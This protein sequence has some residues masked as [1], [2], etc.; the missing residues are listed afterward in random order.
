MLGVFVG[1]PR[2]N[3]PHGVSVKS[4][5]T[6]QNRHRDAFASV[7]HTNN[8]NL[9]IREFG[10][11]ASI[12]PRI[13]LGV[14]AT[15]VPIAR[16]P[17][18]TGVASFLESHVT[19]VIGMCAQEEMRRPTTRSIVATVADQHVVG[20]RT[21]GQYPRYT[22]GGR[23]SLVPGGGFKATIPIGR[24]MPNPFPA[25]VGVVGLEDLAPEPI[26]KGARTRARSRIMGMHGNLL[27][28]CA[29]PGG[30]T[31][32]LGHL[33]AIIAPVACRGNTERVKEKVR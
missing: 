24:L 8:E 5:L 10:L 7:P 23:A 6:G 25:G 16:N 22:L 21:I 30:V 33:Y 2:N 9:F 14:G 31:A 17:V 18:C 1:L 3:S 27:C 19:R 13:S 28:C 29:T 32:P 11:V 12:S 15:P 20:N 4:I 26:S